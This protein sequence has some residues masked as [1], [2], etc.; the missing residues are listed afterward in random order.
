MHA[1]CQRARRH[2]TACM[3]TIE[4]HGRRTAYHAHVLR[5]D[6]FYVCFAVLQSQ[7]AQKTML[8]VECVLPLQ[9]LISQW[10]YRIPNKFWSAVARVRVWAGA[11]GACLCAV[12]SWPVS[13][14]VSQRFY[15]RWGQ[16]ADLTKLQ[17]FIRKRNRQRR[18]YRQT[19]SP[20]DC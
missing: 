12:Q 9:Q 8:A 4:N 2:S 7:P 20:G 5:V 6:W 1:R 15:N 17:S 11:R 18:W 10:N 13:Q 16:L 14:S 3:E 19:K